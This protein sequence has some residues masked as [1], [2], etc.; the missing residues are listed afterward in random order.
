LGR[1]AKVD[2]CAKAWPDVTK[3]A[4]NAPTSNFG[5]AVNSNLAAMVA[6]P[7]DID[8]PQGLDPADAGRRQVVLDKY[9]QGQVTSSQR[10]EQDSGKVK[11]AVN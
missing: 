4:K 6:N 2:D 8:A 9:R 1:Q 3:T 7:A 10:D 11:Q 5:C